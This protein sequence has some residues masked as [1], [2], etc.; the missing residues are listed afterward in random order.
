MC[1]FQLHG[2]VLSISPAVSWVEAPD[3]F[4][5]KDKAVILEVNT[6]ES[7]VEK[8]LAGLP[9]PLPTTTPHPIQQPSPLCPCLKWGQYQADACY[10]STQ[11]H[12]CSSSFRQHY[13]KLLPYYFKWERLIRLSCKSGL[14]LPLWFHDKPESCWTAHAASV[15][16]S[17]FKTTFV[18]P[19][20]KQFDLQPYSMVRCGP[21]SWERLFPFNDSHLQV[22]IT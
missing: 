7:R 8:E 5:P 9:Q 17:S 15:W 10:Q 16:N 1:Y 18:A 6:Q 14:K 21:P 2:L 12:H 11:P 20:W 22:P 19:P 4:I 13:N 3:E